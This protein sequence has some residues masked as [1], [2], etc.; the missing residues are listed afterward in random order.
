MNIHDILLTQTNPAGLNPFRMKLTP[1]LNSS[2]QD[3][4]PLNTPSTNHNPNLFVDEPRP[5][6]A[7][8][9][10]KDKIVIGFVMVNRK[11]D[12]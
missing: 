1:L 10:K 4:E 11:V 7:N 3:N 12:K 8:I 5:K 2:H 6:L 9:A